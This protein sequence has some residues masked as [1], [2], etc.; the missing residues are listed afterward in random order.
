MALLATKTLNAIERAISADQGAAFREN[1]GRVIPHM[2]DAYRGADN[3]FRSHLGAS[4]LGKECGR[5]LWYDFRWS[6][7]PTFT[8][9]TL[10]LFNRGHLEEARFIACLLTIGCT[11]YQQ[12]E[13]GKQYRI[14]D[15]G[16]HLGGSGDGIAIGVPDLP[17][18]LPA[19]LEF[20][21][22]NDASFKSLVKD[23]VRAAKF[24][25]YVQMNCYMRK[26]GLSVALYMAVNK[27]NDELYGELVY[28]DAEC[29]DTFLQRGRTIIMTEEAPPK[30]HESPGWH[31]C[32][33]CDHKPVCHLQMPPARTCRSCQHSVANPTDGKWWCHRPEEGYSAQLSTDDQLR[34]C[35]HY[36]VK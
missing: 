18:E 11:V 19:L 30:L 5:A 27:N 20:K 17:P 8:G 28:L 10:R 25:H 2:S 21:T 34:A 24:E 7:K 36:K 4:L 31:G 3:P 33:W 13:N 12:D 26:M 15:A 16:G 9:R 29:A 23:G 32:R 22:H 6:T 14:S 1:L 35:E